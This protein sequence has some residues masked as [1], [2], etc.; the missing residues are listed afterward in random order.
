MK[1]VEKVHSI[2]FKWKRWDTCPMVLR[3]YVTDEESL[4]SAEVKY[5]NLAV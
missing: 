5:A 1:D 4:A 3:T 2:D